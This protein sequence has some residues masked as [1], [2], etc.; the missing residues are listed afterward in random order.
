MK[1]YEIT[2]ALAVAMKRDGYELDGA[3]RLIIRST[4]SSAI[5]SQRHR[6]DRPR[7]SSSTFTWC[8]PGPRRSC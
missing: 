1:Q 4:V 5:A 7:S 2:E 6:E 8:K 3:D